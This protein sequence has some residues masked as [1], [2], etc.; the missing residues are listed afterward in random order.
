MKAALQL[1]ASLVFGAL[2]FGVALFWPAGTFHY[3]Q[4]WVFIAIFFGSSL[5]PTAYLARKQPA[6]LRR[7]LHAGPTAETRPA[8]RVIISVIVLLVAATYAIS[9]FDH[10]FGWSTVPLAVIVIGDV[11][12]AVGI[13]TAQ[14]VI[15]QN[16]YASANIA[17]EKDQPLVSTGLY[18]VVR[19]PMYLGVVINM[20]GTPI[21]LDS[22]WGFVTVAL[23]IPVFAARV[24]DEERMLVAELGGYR[25]YQ[26][27]VRSRL[28]P[29][30]W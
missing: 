4:A 17:V 14:L 12:V 3:W 1:A 30:V 5:V 9:A 25:E 28:I 29:Q 10:R 22:W 7:R 19:H 15:I 23:A 18:G 27:R 20:I 2:F 16:G 8:Q 13:V 21:A 11:L 6:A 24:V 26:A